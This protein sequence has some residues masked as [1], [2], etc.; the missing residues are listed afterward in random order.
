ML[1]AAI[2]Q[3]DRAELYFDAVESMELDDRLAARA[4]NQLRSDLRSL[5]EYLV[6]LRSATQG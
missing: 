3:L 1:R 4:L 6:D 5:V 2:R